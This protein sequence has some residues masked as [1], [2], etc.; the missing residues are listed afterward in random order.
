MS[1]LKK[2]VDKLA[3]LNVA[4]LEVTASGSGD[5]GTI[6]EPTVIDADG[7]DIEVCEDVTDLIDQAFDEKG[8]DYYN[9]NGG[10]ITLEITVAERTCNWNAYV[11]EEVYCDGESGEEI[12]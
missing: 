6:D 8:F 7:N 1:A 5:D 9:G 3:E 11:V 12:V 2:L 10:S 4:T